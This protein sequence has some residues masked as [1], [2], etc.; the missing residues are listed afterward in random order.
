ML[1][2]MFN[3][4]NITKGQRMLSTETATSFIVSI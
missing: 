4:N 2:D 3:N 1:G